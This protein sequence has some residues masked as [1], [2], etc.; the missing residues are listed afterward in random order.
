MKQSLDISAWQ[1]LYLT[2][3]KPFLLNNPCVLHGF[4]SLEL[5]SHFMGL[6][7]LACA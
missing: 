5:V 6:I 7:E 4:S 2:L 3:F 1:W